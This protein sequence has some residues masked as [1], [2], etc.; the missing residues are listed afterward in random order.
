[1][2][3][4][5][6]SAISGVGKALFARNERKASER[7]NERMSET[8]H[9]REVQD[10][11]KAGLNPI[12]SAGGSGAQVNSAGQASTPTTDLAAG[13]ASGA[14]V[15]LAANSAKK[16]K[17]ETQ[18]TSNQAKL[19]KDALK[20][21]EKNPGIKEKAMVAKASQMVGLPGALSVPAVGSWNT[22]QRLRNW[23]L[24]NLKGANSHMKRLFGDRKEIGEKPKPK[25]KPKPYSEISGAKTPYGF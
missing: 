18:V 12:L 25:K 24:K 8:A 15:K 1:M 6:T 10:L 11:I 5:I 2:L 7:F 9:Q 3:G 20:W 16:I 4:A 13:M 17:A 19:E 22:G 14:Q 21:L 23:Y